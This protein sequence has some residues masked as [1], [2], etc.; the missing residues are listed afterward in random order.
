PPDARKGGVLAV[1]THAYVE[2]IIAAGS[3][4]MPRAYRIFREVSREIGDDAQLIAE[5]F[6]MT[7]RVFSVRFSPDGKRIACGSG[8]DRGGEVLV[9]SYDYT[10]DVPNDLRQLMGKVPGSRK[11]EEQKQLD[12]Y[13]KQGIREVARAPVPQSAIYSVAFSPDGNVVAAGGSDGMVRLIAATNGSLIKSFLSVPVAKGSIAETKP[14]W[15]TA[16]I[17][18]TEPALSPESLPEGAQVASLEIQ[19][20]QLKF[21]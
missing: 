3:D 1:A 19:P 10:N 16:V 5:L 21:D 14:V 13:K 20:A 6:S 7:G 18:S 11:P 2:H 15:G 8:L 12:D 4:G 9:C 17:K